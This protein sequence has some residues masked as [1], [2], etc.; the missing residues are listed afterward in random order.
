ME[1]AIRKA[2]EEA[3]KQRIQERYEE[4]KKELIEDLDREKDQMLAGIVLHLMKQVSFERM[5]DILRIEV[6]TNSIK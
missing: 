1:E 5:G 6:G 4:K 3:L 2:I